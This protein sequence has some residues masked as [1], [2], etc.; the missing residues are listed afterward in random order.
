[1]LAPKATGSAPKCASKKRKNQ[2][3]GIRQRPWGKW[4]AEIRDPRKG[5]RVWLGTFNTAEEAARA[6]DVEARRIRGAKAKVNF[7]DSK[8]SVTL[9]PEAPTKISKKITTTKPTVPAALFNGGG[10][11]AGFSFQSGQSSNSLEGSEFGFESESKS[12]EI[13]SVLSMETETETAFPQKKLKN[14]SGEAFA[15]EEELSDD[16]LGFE[17]YVKFLQV[18]YAEGSSDNSIDDLLS[19]D[20][21]LDCGESLLNLW[22]FDDL[23]GTTIF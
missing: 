18:P 22:G 5:V 9:T 21:T 13:T 23:P 6:Y 4:A 2:F 14:N 10:G 20:L 12:S 7:T 1:M 3:R 19:N 17:P 15:M 8:S 11:G 16:F